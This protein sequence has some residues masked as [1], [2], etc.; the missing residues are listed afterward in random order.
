MMNGFSISKIFSRVGIVCLGLI[1]TQPSLA[2]TPSRSGFQCLKELMSLTSAPFDHELRKGV[3][4]P[5]TARTNN[6]IYIPELASRG[7]KGFYVFTEN[8]ASFYSQAQLSSGELKALDNLPLRSKENPGEFYVYD[9]IMSQEPPETISFGYIPHYV[10]QKGN[11]SSGSALG[12][13]MLP[14][15]GLLFATG[16]SQNR[17]YIDPLSNDF[18]KDRFVKWLNRAP[19]S[20]TGGD[21]LKPEE[22]RLLTKIVRLKPDSD[23]PQKIINTHLKNEILIRLE[24]LQNRRSNASKSKEIH[25]ALANSCTNFDKAIDREVLQTLRKLERDHDLARATPVL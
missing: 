3:A 24:G 6:A 9:L 16:G 10:G 14:V 18:D 7:I 1:Y 5:Q 23:K 15:F 19:A 8:S 2:E 21:L 25:L 22:V 11:G 13:A 17:P 20:R 4:S 12:A